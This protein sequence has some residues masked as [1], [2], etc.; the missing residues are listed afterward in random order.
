[1]LPYGPSAVARANSRK[2][3]ESEGR[4]A[5]LRVS[6]G[7]ICAYNIQTKSKTEHSQSHSVIEEVILTA[8]NNTG[9]IMHQLIFS[10]CMVW[11]DA[12]YYKV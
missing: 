6:E 8:A 2:Q 12:A 3:G 7:A 1:M 5:S 4:T 11:S 9:L 10:A